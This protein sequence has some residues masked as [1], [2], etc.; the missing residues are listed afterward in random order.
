MPY[1]ALVSV[2]LYLLAHIIAAAPN[3]IIDVANIFVS[4]YF[5]FWWRAQAVLPMII[6]VLAPSPS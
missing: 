5:P 6:S 1:P 2:L 3:I 4:I